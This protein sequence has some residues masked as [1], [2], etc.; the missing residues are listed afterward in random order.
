MNNPMNMI[1]PD[2]RETE[3]YITGKDGTVYH[4]NDSKSQEQVDKK[5]GKDSELTYQGEEVIITTNDG[6]K[7]YGDSEGQ[8]SYYLD[9]NVQITAQGNGGGQSGD[10]WGLSFYSGVPIISSPMVQGAGFTPGPFVVTPP[11]VHPNTNKEDRDFIRHE[12]GHVA[13]FVA[14]GASFPL[15]LSLIAIPSAINFHFPDQFGG[16]HDS[17]YTEKIANTFS[18]WMYGPFTGRYKNTYPSYNTPKK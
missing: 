17:F 4:D 12:V 9:L 5:Y 2:G 11:G 7:F 14:M 16:P 8:T 13:T 15:Y 6:T 3:G 18:E 10:G 1:D